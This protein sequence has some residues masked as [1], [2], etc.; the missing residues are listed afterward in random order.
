MTFPRLP[1]RFVPANEE[2]LKAQYAG[3]ESGTTDAGV[4][5]TVP[6]ARM[7]PS[8][9]TAPDRISGNEMFRRYPNGML[10]VDHAKHQ[11]IDALHKVKDKGPLNSMEVVALSVLFPDLFADHFGVVDSATI[12]AVRRVQ[13][14]LHPEETMA[15]AAAVAGHLAEEE[16][17]NAGQGGGSVPGRHITRT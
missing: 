10:D 5:E 1:V 11:V 8:Y 15:I 7:E 3:S 2:L 6:V 16:N 4:N 14:K 9:R 17:Y 12:D 13:L